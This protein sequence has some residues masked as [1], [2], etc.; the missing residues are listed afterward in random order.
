MSSPTPF[1]EQATQSNPHATG[2][3]PD[4]RK[5]FSLTLPLAQGAQARCPMGQGNGPTLDASFFLDIA[6]NPIGFEPTVDLA[7]LAPVM[8]GGRPHAAPLALVHLEELL[9]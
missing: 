4:Y 7:A 3:A 1:L 2:S 9:A 5:D 8:L 6:L